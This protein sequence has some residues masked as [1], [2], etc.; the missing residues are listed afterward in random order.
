MRFDVYR[1]PDVAYPYV[2]DVQ[3]EFVSGIDSRI[4][5]P[6]YRHTKLGKII[7]ELHPVF[8]IEDERFVLATHALSSVPK[9]SLRLPAGSLASHQ[10]EITRAMDL[11]FTGF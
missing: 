3:A 9:R 4:V 1:M 7:K 8:E 2:V 6:L 10:D 5:I 11:L